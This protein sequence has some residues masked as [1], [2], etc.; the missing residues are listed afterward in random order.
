MKFHHQCQK[1]WTKAQ[2]C[3]E[4]GKIAEYD[5]GVGVIDALKCLPLVNII[6]KDAKISIDD[7]KTL[8]NFYNDNIESNEILL[9]QHQNLHALLNAWEF[10]EGEAV[11]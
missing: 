5:I 1:S 8:S 11:T 9:K 3:K 4:D 6:G 10:L 7:L 2:E